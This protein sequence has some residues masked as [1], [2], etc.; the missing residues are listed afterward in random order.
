MNEL[1]Q[2]GRPGQGTQPPDRAHQSPDQARQP[3]QAQQSRPGD[4]AHRPEQQAGPADRRGDQGQANSAD[5]ALSPRLNAYLNSDRQHTAAP[6]PAGRAPGAA[7]PDTTSAKPDSVPAAS[8]SEAPAWDRAGTFRASDL[9]Q[10]DSRGVPGDLMVAVP[11]GGHD[12]MVRMSVEHNQQTGM[13]KVDITAGTD[14]RASVSL[15]TARASDVTFSI[16]PSADPGRIA[17]VKVSAQQPVEITEHSSRDIGIQVAVPFGPATPA[18]LSKHAGQRADRTATQDGDRT[19]GQQRDRT[20]SLHNDH[21]ADQLPA[22]RRPRE[23]PPDA[24]AARGDSRAAPTR[25]PE[26]PADRR[27]DTT[28]ADFQRRLVASGLRAWVENPTPFEQSMAGNKAYQD[29]LDP[30]TGEVLGYRHPYTS[31]NVDHLEIVD[32]NGKV[33]WSGTTGER[34]LTADPVSPADLLTGV[35][36]AA[37]GTAAER[38]LAESAGKTLADTAG[39]IVAKFTGKVVAGEAVNATAGI[40]G[41]AA[42]GDA[43]KILVGDAAKATAAGAGKAAASDASKAAVEA[44]GQRAVGELAPVSELGVASEVPHT[45]FHHIFPQA[46]EFA[47]HWERA[48]ID[49]DQYCVELPEGWHLDQL[50]NQAPL[51]EPPVGK[52]GPGGLWNENWRQFFAEHPNPPTANQIWEQ[53][54]RMIEGFGLPRNFRPFQRHSW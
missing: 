5:P 46:E 2:S 34:A 17:D 14:E 39:R 50:H 27:P 8:G 9:D 41:K 13:T 3:D 29:V 10:V 44:A 26:A 37:I 6:G 19:A 20:A 23:G 28:F 38:I 33:I 42:A 40:A 54:N 35:N 32:R 31:T 49:I 1:D 48:G 24:A 22:A 45:H 21:S 11:H 53:A 18:D 52:L 43:A 15:P 12:V 47:P 36:P 4:S 30:K 7:P 16:R 51:T 25:D